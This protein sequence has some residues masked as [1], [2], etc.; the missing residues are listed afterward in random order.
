MVYSKLRTMPDEQLHP[1]HNEIPLP[2]AP[3]VCV[4]A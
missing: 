3:V 2:N 4:D 1:M